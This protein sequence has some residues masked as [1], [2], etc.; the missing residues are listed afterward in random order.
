MSVSTGRG[1]CTAKTP[2]NGFRPK[3]TLLHRVAWM[4]HASFILS[5]ANSYEYV[6][7]GFTS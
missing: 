3:V 1:L 5:V 2:Y 7:Y 6:T 4:V